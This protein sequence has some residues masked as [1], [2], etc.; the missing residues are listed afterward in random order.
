MIW[1]FGGMATIIGGAKAIGAIRAKLR[2]N[3]EAKAKIMADA[4]AKS[5]IDA[6]AKELDG[7]RDQLQCIGDQVGT[8]QREKLNWAYD[9]FCIKG[10]PLPLIQKNS[11]EKMYKQYT[12]EGGAAMNGVPHDFLAKLSEAKIV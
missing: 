1:L 10:R 5:V 3:K 2:E 8:I 4:I 12:S 11:L 9:Y 7:L 6:Q